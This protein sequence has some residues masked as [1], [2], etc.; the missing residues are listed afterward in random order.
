MK[1]KLFNS[2]FLDVK[3]ID[4]IAKFLSYYLKIDYD[5]IKGNIAFINENQSNYYLI[6]NKEIIYIKIVN[7]FNGITLD[8]IKADKTIVINFLNKDNYD[9]IIMEMIK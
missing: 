8:N 2:F 1:E 4:K 5:K 6:Y 3:N 9:K 7:N